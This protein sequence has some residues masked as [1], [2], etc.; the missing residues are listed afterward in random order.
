MTDKKYHMY[1]RALWWMYVALLLVFVV[2]KFDGS[3]A[4]LRDRMTA[5]PVGPNYNLRPFYTIRVQF[6]FLSR[7]W[8]KL[9]LL[10]NTVPFL[11]F[12]YL[13]PL[14]WP[15]LGTFPRVFL[16]GLSSVLAIE[17]FQYFTRLGRLDVDDV[18]LNMTGVV[19]GYLLLELTGRTGG[20]RQ[21]TGEDAY[22]VQDPQ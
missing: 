15:R 6:K 5:P 7:G 1:A 18:L 11:P 10:G 3:F 21:G 4:A 19:C 22:D 12:G 13:L 20:R 9:N 17:L 14:A 16:T 2:V 8:A